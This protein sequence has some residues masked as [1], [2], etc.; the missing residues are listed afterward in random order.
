MH[1]P[2][3][4][5]ELARLLLTTLREAHLATCDAGQPR[6]RPVSVALVEGAALYIASFRRWGKVAEILVN[7]RAELSF[8]DPSGRHLRLTGE[9]WLREEPALRRR[10]WE[11]FP[12][13]QRYFA[14]PADPDYALLEFCA[15]RVRVKDGWELEYREVPVAALQ[16]PG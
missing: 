6:L 1:P 3:E 14:D 8:L 9:V 13:M 5:G 7:P 2:L 16:P 10:V 12:M 11:T 4:A 15:Q